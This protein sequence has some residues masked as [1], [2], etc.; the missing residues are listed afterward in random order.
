MKAEVWTKTGTSGSYEKSKPRLIWEG[1]LPFIPVPGM[2]LVIGDKWHDVDTVV[3]DTDDS[4]A[5]IRVAWFPLEEQ[6]A[7]ED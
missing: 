5:E 1:E 2:G 4:I 3:Y 6:A 7:E